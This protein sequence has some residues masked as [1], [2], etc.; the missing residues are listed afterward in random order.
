MNLESWFLVLAVPACCAGRQ[1]WFWLRFSSSAIERGR[2]LAAVDEVSFVRSL[3]ALNCRMA[4]RGQSVAP[5]DPLGGAARDDKIAENWKADP[6][7][8]PTG[9]AALI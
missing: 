3:D 6:I 4:S 8:H 9:G 2:S 5:V 7:E 1:F